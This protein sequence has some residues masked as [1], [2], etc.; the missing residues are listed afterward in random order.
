MGKRPSVGNYKRFTVAALP[1]RYAGPVQNACYGLRAELIAQLCDVDVATARR[2]KSGKSRIP[3]CAAMTLLR[4]LTLF[5]KEWAG[6]RLQGEEILSPDGWTINRNHALSVPLL[7]GQ[8]KALEQK[9]KKMREEHERKTAMLLKQLRR[10]KTWEDK[11]DQPAPP[12]EIP[13]I[14]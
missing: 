3:Y 13:L 14:A 4:D 2:W 10:Y 9:M 6:W 11:E 12:D 5:G 1:D 7:E 8:V